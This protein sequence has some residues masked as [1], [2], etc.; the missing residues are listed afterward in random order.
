LWSLAKKKLRLGPAG[1]R[2]EVEKPVSAFAD[3]LSNHYFS[4]FIELNLDFGGSL[5]MTGAGVNPG[6]ITTR[7]VTGC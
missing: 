2:I 5:E 3:G 1:P 7:W 4:R 6:D